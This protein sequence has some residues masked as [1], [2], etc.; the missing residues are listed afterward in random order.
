M[1]TIVYWNVTPVGLLIDNSVWKDPATS[2]FR[3]ETF[4]S[5][6]LI[7]L[8]N[9]TSLADVSWVCVEDAEFNVLFIVI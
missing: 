7:V 8:H 1:K 5:S 6:D 3:T 2:V 4:V 9:I